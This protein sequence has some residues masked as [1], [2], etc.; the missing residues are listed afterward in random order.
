MSF[1]SDKSTIL[2]VHEQRSP[3]RCAAG[4]EII[5][6]LPFGFFPIN[7]I[8]SLGVQLS[9]EVDSGLNDTVTLSLC[10]DQIRA[11]GSSD[12]GKQARAT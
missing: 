8:N 1:G 5:L 4:L 9:G 10:N 3:S 2:T 6:D 12:S 11:M 7:N